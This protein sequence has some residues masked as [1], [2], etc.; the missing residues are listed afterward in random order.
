MVSTFIIFRFIG[1]INTPSLGFPYIPLPSSS[2][3]RSGD[4]VLISICRDIGRPREL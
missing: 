3:C 1:P 2:V 4:I